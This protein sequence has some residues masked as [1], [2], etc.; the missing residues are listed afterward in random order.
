MGEVHTRTFRRFGVS[1]ALLGVRYVYQSSR[2]ADDAG[3][4][5]IP[6]QGTLDLEGEL[7]VLDERLSIR[8]RLANALNQRR[9]DVIG[10]A[11][12]GRAVYATLEARW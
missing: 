7:R 12:S 11:L 10:Y 2:Y 9:F 5:V 4:V 3:L 1:N 6:E 8:G